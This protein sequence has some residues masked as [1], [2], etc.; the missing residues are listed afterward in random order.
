MG[1]GL[2]IL[3]VVLGSFLALLSNE[4]PLRSA[5]F[6]SS[7]RISARESKKPELPLHEATG[8]EPGIRVTLESAKINWDE[9]LRIF[10]AQAR[11]DGLDTKAFSRRYLEQGKTAAVALL[12]P[13]AKTKF[14]DFLAANRELQTFTLEADGYSRGFFAEAAK[15]RAI[16]PRIKNRAQAA[17]HFEASNEVNQLISDLTKQASITDENLNRLAE[18]CEYQNQCMEHSVVRL[19]DA[20]QL[21]SEE[22]F[23]LI[24][25]L[26]KR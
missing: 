20:N 4:S 24:D 12:S 7:P 5:K 13:E 10:S 6:S 9:K 17:L 1:K 11:E 23:Q 22:Q 16:P 8:T 21:L 19:I 25:Q 18:I 14:D 3:G 2:L 15:D 26:I